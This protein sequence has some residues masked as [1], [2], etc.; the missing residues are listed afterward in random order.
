MTEEQMENK[1]KDTRAVLSEVFR[2]YLIV[3]PFKQGI[4]FT[5]SD[6]TWAMGACNRV[7]SNIRDRDTAITDEETNTAGGGMEG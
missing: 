3:I 7:I 1:L 4:W 6:R 2:D 5:C